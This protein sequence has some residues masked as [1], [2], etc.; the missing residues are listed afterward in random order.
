MCIFFQKKEH[1]YLTD[2]ILR[3]SLCKT[4][5]IGCQNG[6]KTLACLQSLPAHMRC[7]DHIRHIIQR[8]VLRRRLCLLYIKSQGLWLLIDWLP[9]P[10]VPILTYSPGH[11]F[12]LAGILSW[13]IILSLV[14]EENLSPSRCSI[15][16][17]GNND[18]FTNWEKKN[19]R[20]PSI[21]LIWAP[22]F[23]L[24]LDSPDFCLHIF[25][26]NTALLFYY[27]S[28]WRVILW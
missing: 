13:N 21:S 25:I 19:F 8:I 20:W 14:P 15:N 26:L 10:Q 18:Q 16:V 2:Y 11:R 23:L 6:H 3:M 22:S 28:F 7:Q 9:H 17:G 4:F 5:N 12:W 24:T 1:V 27:M